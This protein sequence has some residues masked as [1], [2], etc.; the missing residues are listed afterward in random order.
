MG[1]LSNAGLPRQ[2]RRRRDKLEQDR[3]RPE[4]RRPGLLKLGLLRQERGQ[5]QPERLY[6]DPQLPVCEAVQECKL[7]PRRDASQPAARRQTLVPCE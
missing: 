3:P 6:R 2:D 1:L 5:Y 7:E 4:Q